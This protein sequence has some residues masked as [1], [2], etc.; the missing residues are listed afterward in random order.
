[1]R[2]TVG[3]RAE[4]KSFGKIS[5]RTSKGED[6][7]SEIP[8]AAT[9]TKIVA[10]NRICFALTVT[11]VSSNDPCPHGLSVLCGCGGAGATGD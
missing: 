8:V 11:F 2:R 3:E 7:S 9:A 6:S 4:G 5:G 1:M 10:G